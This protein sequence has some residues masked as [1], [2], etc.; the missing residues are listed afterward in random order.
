MKEQQK[1]FADELTSTEETLK[2]EL[3]KLPN[4]PHISVASGRTAED[5][6]VVR[7][8]GE[9]PLLHKGAAPHWDLIKKI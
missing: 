6:V 7:S 5:N 3:V 4:L 9:K 1:S 2:T 8:G